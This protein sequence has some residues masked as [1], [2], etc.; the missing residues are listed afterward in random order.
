M[1]TAVAMRPMEAE[2]TY[3]SLNPKVTEPC[4][5]GAQPDG[6]DLE[7]MM[8]SDPKLEHRWVVWEQHKKADKKVD[9]SDAMRKSAT[10]GTC[11]EFW[12]CWNHI[13]QPSEL[14]DNKKF[15]RE[16]ND[17]QKNIIDSL[18]IFREGVA[19]EWEDP[20]NANGGHFQL[21]LKPQTG[22]GIIDELWNNIVVGMVSGAI[23]PAGMLTGARL[24]DKLDA[25]LKPV[26]RIEL[27][28]N[29]YDVESAANGAVY[30][31]RGSLER[32]MRIGLDG[33][34][35]PISWSRTEVKPHASSS[36]K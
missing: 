33:K 3:F 26:L 2:S 23:E 7:K 21:Q 5:L 24:V 4:R 18:M 36:P 16:T 11:K 14:L 22:A 25:R 29:E 10:F 13:P 20:Q 27:W 34:D 9:Y 31:L 30:D 6:E 17:G 32:C 28:F 19:P 15:V 1:A 8:A 35:K 12:S